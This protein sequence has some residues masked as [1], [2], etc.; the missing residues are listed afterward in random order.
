MP[1]PVTVKIKF[2]S[3][4][5]EQFMK[6]YSPDVSQDGVFIRTTKPLSIG[7][8]LSFEFRLQDGSPLLSGDGTVVWV[9]DNGDNKTATGM[10]V[11]FDR[12]PPDSQDVIRKVLEY[13][14]STD[15][16]DETPTRT[17]ITRNDDA[18]HG[19]ANLVEDE[20]TDVQTQKFQPDSPGGAIPA[21]AD[22]LQTD[23]A[24]GAL[25]TQERVSPIQEVHTT[26]DSVSETLPQAPGRDD[27]TNHPLPQSAASTETHKPHRHGS[28]EQMLFASSNPAIPDVS[29]A[30]PLE[31]GGSHPTLSTDIVPR[32]TGSHARIQPERRSPAMVW[33]VLVVVVM[34]GAGTYFCYKYYLQPDPATVAAPPDLPTPS[35]TKPPPPPPEPRVT[36]RVT[37]TPE[38]A[39]I[40]ID[41]KDTGRLTPTTL[42]GLIGNKT[43][44][45]GFELPGMKTVR[46]TQKPKDGPVNVTIDD[47]ISRN[48][49]FVSDPAGAKVILNGKVVG[50]T[51]ALYSKPINAAR[52]N[53]VA[54]RL[55][56][57]QLLR[58]QFGGRTSK[59]LR[60]VREGDNDVFLVQATLTK[61]TQNKRRS[62]PAKPALKAQQPVKTPK[63]KTVSPVKPSTEPSSASTPKSTKP[64]KPEPPK[65]A[66][67]KTPEKTTEK[68]ADKK[69]VEKA[70]A[71]NSNTP[72]KPKPDEKTD[73]A[74]KLPSWGQ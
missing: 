74:I 57:Y 65:T 5:L 37:S 33:L 15:E 72:A 44:T 50:T 58:T 66:P 40:F 31:S 11:R 24:S 8:G 71:G 68:T 13:K 20:L 67:E 59:P 49:R 12:L 32:V 54:F 38:G 41:D 64:A 16:F 42:E 48:V 73:P 55:R 23:A 21:G 22:I 9:R 19:A 18:A 27:P 6:L 2:K 46:V 62:L 34:L 10:G 53:R 69:T 63:E 14:E 4:T 47:P 3:A 52:T 43:I 51:P 29:G 36:M 39:K 60:W 1:S 30:A 25:E 26:S 28:L 35:A 56:G 7:T 70:P 17:T 45:L 61:N